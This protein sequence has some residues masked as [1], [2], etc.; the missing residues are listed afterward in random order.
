MVWLEK[1]DGE[2]LSQ[3]V[4]TLSSSA[5]F[6]DLDA[7]Q[8]YRIYTVTHAG[9]KDMP[10]N[11]QSEVLVCRTLQT[12]TIGP[13][14]T[15]SLSDDM[16][17]ALSTKICIGLFVVSIIV[18]CFLIGLCVYHCKNRLFNR[19]IDHG[20]N[21]QQQEHMLSEQR[22]CTINSETRLTLYEV[23]NSERRNEE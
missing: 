3:K 10:N 12:S 20:N 2:K 23:D 1:N 6:T 22:S 4:S 16:T 17:M 18:V 21:P 11:M 7:D 8:E 13:T 5:F 15:N 9:Q 14:K 19:D